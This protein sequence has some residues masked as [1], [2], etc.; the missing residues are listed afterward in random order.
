MLCSYAVIFLA[1][2]GQC[3]HIVNNG[4]E[5]YPLLLYDVLWCGR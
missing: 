1:V 3:F 4:E 2:C 5:G